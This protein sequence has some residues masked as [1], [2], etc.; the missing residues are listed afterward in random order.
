[1]DTLLGLLV[2]AQWVSISVSG[3]KVL[4]NLQAA[5]VGLSHL[6]TVSLDM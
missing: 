1:M 4:A 5:A 3:C 2:L 6:R